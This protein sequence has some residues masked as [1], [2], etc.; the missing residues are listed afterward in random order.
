MLKISFSCL[1]GFSDSAEQKIWQLGCLTWEHIAY[2]PSGTFSPDKTRSLAT[3]INRAKIAYIAQLPDYF[4]HRFKHAN[5]VRVFKDFQEN[6]AVLDIETTGLGK[7]DI[8]TTI[9]L[10]KKGIIHVF[11][12]GVDLDNFLFMLK[13]VR[14]LITFNG[15]RFDLPFLRKHFSIDLNMPH[16]DLMPVLN[17]LGYRGG[18]KKCEETCLMRRTFSQCKSGKDAIRLWKEWESKKNRNALQNLAVYNAEDVF[19]I[20]K[21]AV[22]AYNRVMKI[23]PMEIFMT[24]SIKNQCLALDL[25]ECSV[26]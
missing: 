6:S 14:L 12:N 15:T 8:V 18:Q 13:D 2:L 1:K 17:A 19:M 3:E 26:L 25:I 7:K 23:Y 21:L 5:K 22:M 11:I 16:L 4:I 20:E 24:S 10:L 9:A